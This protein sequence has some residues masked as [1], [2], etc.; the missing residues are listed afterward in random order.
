[1]LDERFIVAQS[2]MLRAIYLPRGLRTDIL[3]SIANAPV[4]WPSWGMT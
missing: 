2:T 4:L 1:M 3:P